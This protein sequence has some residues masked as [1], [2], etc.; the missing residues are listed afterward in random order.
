MQNL[1]TVLSRTIQNLHVTAAVTLIHC[2]LQ[3]LVL[4]H[5]QMPRNE[6]LRVQTDLGFL[7]TYYVALAQM[8]IHETFVLFSFINFS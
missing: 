4:Q 8:S 7:G 1:N 3:Q 6:I 5:S 2:Q